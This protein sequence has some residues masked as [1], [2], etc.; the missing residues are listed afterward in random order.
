MTI[1]TFYVKYGNY[2]FSPFNKKILPK[3]TLP[4]IKHKN[5]VKCMWSKKTKIF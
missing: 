5:N 4:I 1:T 3:M 2:Q